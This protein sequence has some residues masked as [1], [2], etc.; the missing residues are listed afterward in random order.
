MRNGHEAGLGFLY[1]SQGI[2]EDGRRCQMGVKPGADREMDR[3]VAFNV[4][5]IPE[6]KPGRDRISMTYEVGHVPRPSID[7]ARGLL[8][9]PHSLS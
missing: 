2:R 7:V 6:L 4:D 5:T 8:Q 1:S 3:R 9:E